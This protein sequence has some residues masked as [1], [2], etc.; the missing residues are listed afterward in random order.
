MIRRLTLL[1]VLFAGP[2]FAQAQVPIPINGP[3]Q[4]P[5]GPR[6][7][8]VA[9]PVALTIAAYD[10][11]QDGLVTRAELVAGA[12]RSFASVAKGAADIGYIGYG[13]WAL[14]WLGDANALP[15]QF[16]VDGDHN[17]RI[18]QAE[19]TA[20]LMRAFV[21]FDLNKDGVLSRAELITLRSTQFGDGYR[22]DDKKKGGRSDGRPP[23]R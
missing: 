4:P 13:D 6:P 16:D 3:I 2:A 14:R 19:L 23:R 15:S 10:A 11:D 12:A 5:P 8:I 20:T 17:D 1:L 22:P 18:T 21:R 9:E 7:T